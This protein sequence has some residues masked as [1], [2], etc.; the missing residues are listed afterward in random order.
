MQF[1]TQ[2][3]EFDFR[4]QRFLKQRWETSTGKYVLEKI[5]SGIKNSIEIRGILDRYVLD[6]PENSDPYSHPIYPLECL[7]PE[8]FWVLNNDDLR[9]IQCFNE[10][11]GASPSFEKKRLDYAEFFNCSFE[12]TDISMCSLTRAKFYNCNMKGAILGLSGGFYTRFHC[13]NLRDASFYDTGFISPNFT[14]SDLTNAYWEDADIIDPLIDHTTEFGLEISKVWQGNTLPLSQL[15]DIYRMIRIGSEKAELHAQ[16]DYYLYKE[17]NSFRRYILVPRVN[18]NKTLKGILEIQIDRLWDWTTGYGVKPF[19]I[20]PLGI[21]LI[22]LFGVA[23]FFTGIPFG[24][25]TAAPNFVE[26]L[27]FSITSFA[28][29]GYGD[30]TYSAN[31]PTL[32]ILSAVEALL[33]AA[34]I[35]T[36][37][38][39][40]SR[41]IIR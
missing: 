30:L 19:R 23:Y 38:A 1:D 11:F 3:R 21:F 16:T 31:Y 14:G 39:V 12:G 34:W 13:C 17:R 36:F 28:T 33:G 22:M 15:P 5:I 37:I 24:Q 20:M 40:L 2:G 26:C 18:K 32:R 7:N 41:K 4:T 8:E 27:Y 35:A 9:G 10:N 29:L 6:H 25:N